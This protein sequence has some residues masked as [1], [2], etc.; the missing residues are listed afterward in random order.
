MLASSRHLYDFGPFRLDLKTRMLSR[1][2]AYVPLTPKA[3]E[4]LA[5]LI[6]NNTK[7]LRDFGCPDREQ[8]ADRRQGGIAPPGLAWD[9]RRGSHSRQDRFHSA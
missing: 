5:V 2:G 4:T 9:I 8:R 7:S 1:D 3:F 6:E